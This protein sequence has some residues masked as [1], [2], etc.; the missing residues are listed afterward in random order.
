MTSK[1][2]LKDVPYNAV[3]TG[4]ASGIGEAVCRKLASRG[5][6]IV[7]ADLN[8]DRGE[9]LAAELSKI[10]SIDAVFITVDVTKEEDIKR[11]V[12]FAA[13]RW[14]RLDYAANCAGVCIEDA[15]NEEE[16]VS[17]DV[18]DK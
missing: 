8:A 6:S 16:S 13:N 15:W 7:V 14:G 17:A 10:Y 9:R 4:G 1:T 5:I 3:V 18:F 12:E 11:M 2:T